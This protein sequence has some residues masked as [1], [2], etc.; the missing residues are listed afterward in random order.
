[1]APHFSSQ[2]PDLREEICMTICNEEMIN[3]WMI[4]QDFAVVLEHEPGNP[5]IRRML[6]D[7]R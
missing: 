4:D 1:M 7:H 2:V 5:G 6:L 3:Q